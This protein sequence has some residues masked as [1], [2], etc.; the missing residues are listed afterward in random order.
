M[1]G[2]R[3]R[4]LG[5]PVAFGETDRSELDAVRARVRAVDQKAREAR[6]D[7]SPIHPEA[8]A[9]EVESILHARRTTCLFVSNDHG[10]RQV[11]MEQRV[12]AGTTVDLARQL[13]ADGHATATVLAQALVTLENRDIRTG[14]HIRG[15]Q[16][17]FPRRS[18]PSTRSAS[19]PPAPPPPEH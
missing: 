8:H 7:Q 14:E 15:T 4:W 18:R 13:V 19:P 17:L 5:E 10:A 9:G 16:D 1:T 6:G 12:Y 3:N 11:A 2:T